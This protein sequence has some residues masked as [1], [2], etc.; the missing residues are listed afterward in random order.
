MKDARTSVDTD[1]VCNCSRVSV[2]TDN[3]DSMT[4]ISTSTRANFKNT[5]Q[6]STFAMLVRFKI[7]F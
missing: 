4:D 6:H 1:E 2:R 5:E 7:S 3:F